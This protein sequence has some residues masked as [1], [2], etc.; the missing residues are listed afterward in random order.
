MSR[1]RPDPHQA[2]A[3]PVL[4]RIGA[5]LP[6]ARRSAGLALARAWLGSFPLYDLREQQPAQLAAAVQ[7]HLDYG[8]RR[9]R[10]QTLLRIMRPPAAVAGD[11][12]PY[13]VLQLVSDDMPFLVDTLTMTLASAGLLLHLMAHPI[14][15]VRRTVRGE[16]RDIGVGRRAPAAGRSQR[17][18]SWQYLL[19]DALPDEPTR[20]ALERRMRAALKDLQL[21]VGDWQRMRTALQSIIDDLK[22]RPPS[23][24]REVLRESQAFLEWMLADHYTFLGFRASRVSR[25]SGR[26]ALR[27]VAGTQLGILRARREGSYPV[28]S[29]DLQREARSNALLVITKGRDLATVHRPD[30]L[31]YVGIKRYDVRGRLVGEWGF[32]GLWT[33]SVY[34]GNPHDVPLLRLKLARVAGHFDLPPD[35]HDGKRLRQIIDTLPRDELLQ[36]QVPDLVRFTTQILGLQE[37]RRVLVLLRHEP[38]RRYYTCLVFVPRERYDERLLSRIRELALAAVGG[39]RV[40]ADVDVFDA[41]MVRVHLLLRVDPL[42]PVLKIDVAQLEAAIAA[43]AVTWRDSLRTALAGRTDAASAARLAAAYAQRLPHAYQDEVGARQ[44]VA[45][46]LDLAQLTAQVPLRLHLGRAT[47]DAGQRVHLRRVALGAAT[48]I[49]DILPVLEN[50]G[51]RVIAEQAWTLHTESD[52]PAVIQD[53]ALEQRDGLRIDVDRDAPKFLEALTLTLDGT[54]ENDGFDRLLLLAQLDAREIL[55]LRA[56]CRYLLQSGLPFSQAY[57]ERVLAAHSRVAQLLA[58]LFRL[59]LDPALPR[60]AALR[61]AARVAAAIRAQLERVA[62]LDEDRILRSLLLLQL[63]ITRTSHFQP[64]VGARAGAIAQTLSIKLDPRLLPDLPKPVPLHEIYVYGVRVEGVHL[65]MGNVARGGLR[66]SDRREDFRTEVLGLMKAQHVKN[67]LIVPVGAKGGFVVRRLSPTDTREAQQREVVDCYS[68]FVGAL[69]D[70]TDNLRGKQV[71]PPAAT[72]RHDADDPYFVVAADKGTATFS[73]T[74]NAIA[75][76]RGFWLGDAFASGGS[77]GYDHKA[78]GITARGAWE[79]VR[80]HFREMGVDIQQQ[81][82][83]VAG[84]GDMAGDVFGNGMLLS[85]HIRLQAAFNH[86]HIFIDPEPAAARSYRERT[87]LAAL[88]RSSWADYDSRLISAGGGVFARSAK[89]IPLSPQLLQLVA[90]AL[91]GRKSATPVEVIRALLGMRVDLL[92]NGGIGTYVKA[93]TESQ[94]AAGDRGNDAVRIDGREVR[95]RVVGEGGNLGFTQ[96][97]RIE[98]ALAGGRINTDSID[99]SAGV[100]TSDVEVNYKIL[101][102]GVPLPRRNALLKRVTPDVAALV[103]RN[104]IL[105]SQALSVMQPDSVLHLADYQALIRSL[106]RVEGLDPALEHLPTDDEFAERSVRGQG[107]TRPELAVLLS[108]QKLSMNRELLQSSLPEDP[109]FATELQRYFATPIARRYPRA[110]QRHRL[111]REIIATATSNSLINRMGPSFVSQMS[112][113]TSA[114]PPQIARAYTIVRETLQLRALWQQIED[115]DSQ[116]PSATQYLALSE[117]IEVTRQLCHWLLQY[118]RQRLDVAASIRELGAPVAEL[119]ARVHETL[120][121]DELRHYEQ[122]L[123]QF[124]SGRLPAKLAA[125]VAAQAALKPAFDLVELARGARRPV[126][127]VAGLYATL[128]SA[129]GL[130]WLRQRAQSLPAQGSWHGAARDAL[131]DASY[132][133]QRHATEQALRLRGSD[134]LRATKFLKAQHEAQQTWS[135]MLGQMRAAT[136]VDFAALSVGIETVRKLT[137]R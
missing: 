26:L 6:A 114:T 58:R 110:I 131:V 118:R 135:A 32:L 77:A 10:G 14:V 124:T 123:A 95:A 83:T 99:N 90:P 129:L 38:F 134:A 4:R 64:R 39:F 133:I 2:L 84:I 34:R 104:N 81:D 101:L 43:S 20:M 1:R 50:F 111:R 15:Q 65:R 46:V 55:V 74:A 108:W 92:W 62:S 18:E 25:R 57:M 45:D 80:R 68:L 78:M 21:A 120:R 105:Q 87:R 94:L 60:K 98:Y 44:A 24:P 115:V 56:C 3:A 8:W 137:A 126:H 97:G 73:D 96:R 36:A 37:R 86:Q 41:S 88:P 66:W 13:A 23:R 31:D 40:T 61:D 79:C 69:L 112:D 75:L 53:L 130:D 12:A 136:E 30:H 107:L 67:S 132:R 103:L 59:R 33:T 17:A 11:A 9:R 49:S 42:A 52:Q 28:R 85:P 93:S 27:P 128:G 7:E 70:V 5:A 91:A 82:F 100:N 121:G 116:V 71:L 54:T 125:Q 47:G 76:A 19:I 127:Q 102:T 119:R 29:A 72:V 16:L 89:A 51:L 122:R 35:S 106:V 109:Y 63:A 48:P 117:S 22:A 113:A